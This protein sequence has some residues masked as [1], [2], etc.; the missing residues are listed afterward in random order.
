MTTLTYLQLKN[1]DTKDNT[2]YLDEDTHTYTV[3]GDTSFISSTTIIHQYFS[4]FDADK[5]IT[6][7]MKSKNW[8]KNKYYGLTPDEIKRKWESNGKNSRELGT[9]LHYD[10]ECFYNKKNVE[11]ITI[12]YKYFKNY[13]NDFS[14][15]VPYRTEWKIYDNYLKW[16]G[17][18][19]MLYINTDNSLSIYDW[20]RSK[21]IEK[22]SRY[23]KWA[24][25]PELSHLPDTNYWHYSLQLNIYKYILE[26]NYNK[27]IKDMNL[28]IFHENNSNYKIIPVI[29]LSNE[30]NILVKLRKNYLNK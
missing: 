9:Q 17:T 23:N 14:H 4:K 16:V 20:K 27:K 6:K 15:L 21:S 2:I 10:I 28:V 12:E 11:N 30:I 3:N 18:V 7:M 25:E 19:D 8:S 24:L 26:N 5:I 1:P 22:T 29:N 13:A